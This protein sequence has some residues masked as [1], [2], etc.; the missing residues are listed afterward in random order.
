MNS[1]YQYGSNPLKKISPFPGLTA[2]DDYGNLVS[3]NILNEPTI[4]V[5]TVLEADTR[6][7]SFE[8]PIVALKGFWALS[9]NEAIL[10]NH[11]IDL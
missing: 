7:D 10:F 11:G 3:F 6:L 1:Y 8:N 5:K 2:Y 4:I 9:K